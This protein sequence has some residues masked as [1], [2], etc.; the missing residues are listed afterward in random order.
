MRQLRRLNHEV[1]VE[2]QVE[3]DRPLTPAAC[4]RRRW[5]VFST[6]KSVPS[7]SCGGKVGLDQAGAVEV[8]GLVGRTSHGP[9]LAIAADREQL[10][11]RHEPEQLDRPVE[12]LTSAAQG[13]N[14]I[15]SGIV[16]WQI[17]AHIRVGEIL[18]RLPPPRQLPAARGRRTVKSGGTSRPR[19]RSST[20]DP[21]SRR[22]PNSLEWCEIVGVPLQPREP[23]LCTPPGDTPAA[24]FER[25][26]REAGKRVT[27]ESVFRAAMIQGNTSTM[28]CLSSLQRTSLTMCGILWGAPSCQAVAGT[29]RTCH[30]A[31]SSS[32]MTGGIAVWQRKNISVPAVQAL[33]ESKMRCCAARSKLAAGVSMRHRDACSQYS[34]IRHAT[35]D[36]DHDART[37]CTI[38]DFR[39]PCGRPT[40]DAA[41]VI[42]RRDNHMSDAARRDPSDP[43]GSR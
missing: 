30:R 16:P 36:T 25:S 10:H 12:L 9:R 37:P 8:G 5:S 13:W 7:T 4:S 35:P 32:C 23:P 39:G 21:S 29:R 41:T 11:A 14:R 42:C 26:P 2:Q 34:S 33:S 6:A 1:V 19:P 27:E 20:V 40:P 28:S 22:P 43:M 15:R 17:P 18:P 24:G 31:M 3:V 38:P